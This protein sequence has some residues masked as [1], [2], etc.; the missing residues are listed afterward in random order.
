M[1]HTLPSPFRFFVLA[2]MFT[3]ATGCRALTTFNFYGADTIFYRNSFQDLLTIHE[4]VNK[5]IERAYKANNIE[6]LALLTFLDSQNL[7]AMG[8]YEESVKYGEQSVSYYERLLEDPQKGEDADYLYG[9]YIALFQLTQVHYSVNA[10]LNKILECLEKG[11]QVMMKWATLTAQRDKEDIKAYIQI[12]RMQVLNAQL[13]YIMLSQSHDYVE[14]EAAVQ[15]MVKMIEVMYDD[16]AHTSPEYAVALQCYASLYD[17]LEDFE[18]ARNYWFESLRI[19]E[20]SLG[21]RSRLYAYTLKQIAA[22]Y[23]SL[24]DLITANKYFEQSLNLY[25]A[26]GFQ[27]SAEMVDLSNLGGLIF[28]GW[29]HPDDAL[30]CFKTAETVAIATCGKASF[31][32]YETKLWTVY[33]LLLKRQYKQVEK[34]LKEVINAEPFHL[35]FSGD[36][37]LLAYTCV[38]EM[39]RMQGDY[40]Y[41]YKHE[42]EIEDIISFFKYPS[43][44]GQR[45]FYLTV[46]RTYQTAG[47]QLEACR[48]FA[49]ALDFQRDI[50]RK[51][52]AFLSENQRRTLWSV[53]E[54]RLNSVMQ[55]NSFPRVG[56]SPVGTLLYDAALLQKGMLLEASINM[57]RIVEDKGS[58]ELKQKMRQLQLMSQSQLDARQ[59]QQYQL[60]EA[61]VQREARNYGDFMDYANVTWKDVQQ[62]LDAHSV[63][64]EFICS[65]TNGKRCYSAEVL[66]SDLDQP[67][68]LHLFTIEKDELTHGAADGQFNDFAREN[69]WSAALLSLFQPG[70]HIYFS[71]AG[72][73]HK[74]P[75]E[76]LTLPD[77]RRVNEVF[78]MHR[79]SSTR[80]LATRR[81]RTNQARSIALFGG[82]NYNATA[83]DRDLASAA[84]RGKAKASAPSLWVNLPGTLK[85]V[86][87]IA[88]IMRQQRYTVRLVTRSNGTEQQFRT[89]SGSRTGIIHVATHA[90]FTPSQPNDMNATGLIFAGGNKHWLTRSTSSDPAVNPADDILTSSEIANLNL[91]GTDMV[92]LSACQTGLGNITGEGVFGLQRAFKKAGVQSLLMSLWEVDDEATQ[93][94]M[95]AFY[96]HYAG[97]ATKQEALQRAQQE[98]RQHT[99][100]RNGQLLRG[101]DPRL[102]AAFILMDE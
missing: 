87:G 3:I 42:K 94:L 75:I 12:A 22:N 30:S 27:V 16:E 40:K 44:N 29:N 57:A 88:P 89:L 98:L 32:Y 45:Q 78:H 60:L 9:Y 50:T 15:E 35:N 23:Y 34:N 83:A 58:P 95:T 51:N 46:G 14:A 72:E 56:A 28:Y 36:H 86:E 31:P 59:Q 65:E 81:T 97:G 24:A 48:G 85:E 49:K 39:K 2:L 25:Q 66:R 11:G 7:M 91:I 21:K 52:F 33:P 101:D 79:L 1:R 43:P 13:K 62:S 73:L 84:T 70:D 77:G 82:F 64:I 47:K 10:D 63:A 90:F 26:L 67:Y 38:L 93:L 99:F 18:Q 4:N 17:A 69:I 71:P 5:D 96:R 19:V 6:A 80:E 68:H 55:Q 37:L 76:Y 92:V 61:E 20:K 102:W 41:L 53:E 54:R 8:F 74:L 100:Q